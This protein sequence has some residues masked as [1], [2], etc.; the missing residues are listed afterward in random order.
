MNQHIWIKETNKTYHEQKLLH[1][2]AAFNSMC[3][4]EEKGL[5]V[6]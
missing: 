5:K 2:S 1:F 6:Q 3:G 4:V